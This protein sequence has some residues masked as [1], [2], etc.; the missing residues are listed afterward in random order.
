M[1][2]RAIYGLMLCLILAM[3]GCARFTTQKQRDYQTIPESG[4]RN[5]QLARQKNNQAIELLC[6]DNCNQAE[7]LLNEALIADVD[8]GPA[9]NTLGKVYFKAKKYYLAAWEF[10]YAQRLMPERTEP[11]NNLGLVFEAVGQFDHAVAYFEQAVAMSPETPQY[12][13]NLIRS[14]LSRGDTPFELQGEI[15]NLILIDDRPEWVNWAKLKLLS[16]DTESKLL[17]DMHNPSVDATNDLL[18][19]SN[20][21][22]P[23]ETTKQDSPNDLLNQQ[24][25]NFSDDIQISPTEIPNLEEL[26]LNGENIEN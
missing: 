6:Q 2:I 17:R 19:P 24:F 26:P 13:G 8:F 15:K 22:L 18:V 5:T 3:C 20:F 11:V 7:K 1:N 14:R 25:H 23:F 9:H 10:E 12:L 21:E 4:F 16:D